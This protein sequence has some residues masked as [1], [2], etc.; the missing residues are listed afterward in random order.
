MSELDFGTAFRWATGFKPFAYQCQLAC[1]EGADAD[2]P[3]TLRSG[4]N[5]ESKLINV[6]TGLGKTAAVVL[7]WLWN[8]VL[9]PDTAI[10]SQWPRRLL[11]CLPMRT[12]VEQTRDNV[13]EWLTR[14]TYAAAA[15]QQIVGTRIGKLS[16]ES[17][18]RLEG[19]RIE[20]P[21]SN[22]L[23]H[24]KDDLLWLLE[25]SPVVLMGGEELDHPHRDWD[26]YPEKAAILIGTQDMLL[27]RALNR[28]YG[29]SRYRWPM[30]FGL[31]NNDC[32]W[33]MDETQLMGVGVETSA[34]LEGFRNEGKI[35]A[36]PACSTWWMSA[37]LDEARLETIDH[38]KPGGGWRVMQLDED[39][40]ALPAV[41]DRYNAKKKISRAALA[42]DSAEKAEYARPLADFIVE[43]HQRALD[44]LTL[45][46]VNNVRRAQ[47][48]YE[49]LQKTGA[50]DRIALI[51]SRFRPPDRKRAE[52]ILFTGGGRIV[53]ATQAVEAGVDVSAGMLITELAPWS[54]LVQRFGRCNRYGEFAE[55][56]EIFWIDIK[57]RDEKD[58]LVLPYS[59][60]QLKIARDLLERLGEDAGPRSLREKIDYQ[61]PLEIR[62]VIRRKDL[63]DLFDT[64]PDLCGN[65]L[66]ISLYVRD[67]DDTDV[68]VYWR[69]VPK[70]GPPPDDEPRPRRD[71]LCAVSLRSFAGFLQKAKKKKLRVLWWNPVEEK[72][73]ES[74]RARPGQL[75]LLVQEV[76]GYSD[77]LGWTGDPSDKPAFVFAPPRHELR[78]S[79][80]RDPDSFTGRFVLLDK[81]ARDVV[82]ELEKLVAV[83][84][85]DDETAAA[86]CVAARWHDVGKAHEE[87][88]KMLHA[89]ASSDYALELLAKS[90]NQE[91][92][93]ARR[94]FRHELASALAWLQN[95]P[96]DT[97][98]PDLVAFLIAAHHGKVRLS[99]R[100][101]PNETPPPRVDRLYARG[102][103]DGDSLPGP[104][105]E[106]FSVNGQTITRFQLDLSLMQL[107]DGPRGPSWLARMVALRD[108]LGPFR[109]AWL[110]TLLRVADARASD[111]EQ[112]PE[113][114]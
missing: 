10:R 81:H 92:R 23:S 61:P 93:C 18:K 73:D 76:G 87:F 56:A 101:L 45:V 80:S 72:W 31:L 79:G 108:R 27:S 14:L 59:V 103:W 47:D 74:N 43:R 94:F 67:S 114:A 34:Q 41:L 22:H 71:E 84:A 30:H 82:E 29:M 4:S 17:Q 97:P 111:A 68:R 102:I 110:E 36:Q 107:G 86:L 64:T 63:F 100:S 105:F 66:D 12:L 5:C 90:K 104:P 60:D 95:A 49:Q 16:E 28:G 46:V 99:I 83:L 11:Y 78:D 52:E 69:E 42:L 6:P 54:S 85:L 96:A 44:S 77:A 106:T 65:D 24:A 89:G 38:T 33:V 70:D 20:W 50:A 21:H 98:A 13:S 112:Q 88:Q 57:P 109:L 113:Q 35:G 37:T 58:E 55:G 1:S 7:A 8:R 3:G 15:D 39:D 19:A 9:C 53:V 26:L 62:P 32:L 25:H 40:L 48:V 51:H 75:Y 2:D 91:G